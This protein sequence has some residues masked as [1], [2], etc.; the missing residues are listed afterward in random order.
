MTAGFGLR[1]MATAASGSGGFEI[2]TSVL[3]PW[4]EISSTRRLMR[5][6]GAIPTMGV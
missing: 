3:Y 2:R 4:C 5:G 6:R 1:S